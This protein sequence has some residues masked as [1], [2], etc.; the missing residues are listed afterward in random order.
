MLIFFDF[1]DNQKQTDY[2]QQQEEPLKL[3]R[4]AI[5]TVP[6]GEITHSNYRLG[7]AKNTQTK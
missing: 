3:G 6:N 7:I 4:N 2:T 5:Y 1:S